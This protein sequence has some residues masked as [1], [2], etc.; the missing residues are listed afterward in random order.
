VETSKPSPA[1]GDTIF[2]RSLIDEFQL[3]PARVGYKDKAGYVNPVS[4]GLLY[5]Q[6]LHYLAHQHIANDGPWRGNFDEWFEP[7]LVENYDWDIARIPNY[8]AFKESIMYAYM[9]WVLEVWPE[10]EPLVRRYEHYVEQTLYWERM[11][12]VWLSGT[13]DLFNGIDLVDWKTTNAGWQW[14]SQK[15]DFAIQPSIYAALHSYNFDALPGSFIFYVWDRKKME[16]N[17]YATTRSQEQIDASVRT[18]DE[19]IRQYVQ[20]IFPATM[21]VEGR[22]GKKKRGWYCSAKWCPAWNICE[23]KWLNDGVD[24][25]ELAV[26]EWR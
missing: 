13:P 14:N 8:D 2:R 20:G 23:H 10:Q 25:S 17:K 1:E 4:D 22:D 9:R 6:G 15:A 24:E 7:Y 11:P 19:Y 5:G 18:A 3:C 16:W 21:V 12:N 26:K